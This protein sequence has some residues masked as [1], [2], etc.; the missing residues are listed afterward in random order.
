MKCQDPETRDIS[1][2]NLTFQIRGA[3]RLIDL[4]RG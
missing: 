2:W 4:P 3:V 1:L